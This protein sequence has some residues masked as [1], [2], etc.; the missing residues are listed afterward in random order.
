MTARIAWDPVVAVAAD[1]VRSYD[2]PV[3]LRQVFYRLV[4][5]ELI[6]NT[7]SAYKPFPPVPLRLGERAGSPVWPTTLGQSNGPAD[8]T[9]PPLRWRT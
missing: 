8:G 1:V 4:A 6:P 7:H 9:D 5:A 2:T 3:T